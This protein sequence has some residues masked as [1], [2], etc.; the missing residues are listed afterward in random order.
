VLFEKYLELI[1]EYHTC[2]GLPSLAG[3]NAARP[4]YPALKTLGYFRVS[5]QDKERLDRSN[6][7]AGI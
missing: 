1:F 7:R 6:P 2:G 5:L 4:L 3:L